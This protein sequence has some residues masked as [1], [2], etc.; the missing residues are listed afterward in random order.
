M[1]IEIK[2]LNNFAKTELKKS[3]KVFQHRGLFTGWVNECLIIKITIPMKV[4]PDLIRY[5]VEKDIMEKIGLKASVDY[6]VMVS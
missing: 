4:D 1:R 5:K 6:M 2:P 3:L